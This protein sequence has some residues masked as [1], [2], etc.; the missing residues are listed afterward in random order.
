MR[1][2]PVTL[3]VAAGEA[4]HFNSEDLEKGNV[5]KGLSGGT[6]APDRGD[7]RLELDSD[8]AVEVLSYIRTEDGFLTAMHDTAP[9]TAERHRVATFNPGSNE[10]QAS[11]LRLVN[12]G[13]ELAE[14]AITGIDDDGE[15]AGGG[16]TVSIGAGASRTLTARALESGEG[17]QGALGDGA[18]KWRLLVESDRPVVVMSLLESPTGHLTNLSTAPGRKVPET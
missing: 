6:G 15:S 10:R 12:P 16:V 1:A 2:G 18:G 17:V 7:W 4:V 13:G 3:S 11:R 14:V 9:R 8:L 5:G